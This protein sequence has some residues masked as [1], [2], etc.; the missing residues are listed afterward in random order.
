[1]ERY[2]PPRNAC[3]P[4]DDDP[5]FPLMTP[6]IEIFEADLLVFIVLGGL[7]QLLFGNE[8]QLSK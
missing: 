4:A 3:F 6:V 2:A 1:V 7:I 8:S 5:K